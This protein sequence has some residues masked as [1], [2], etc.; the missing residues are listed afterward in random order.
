M[1]EIMTQTKVLLLAVGGLVVALL[2]CI[3]SASLLVNN[4]KEVPDGILAI[5]SAAVGALSTMLVTPR[6]ERRATDF[7]ERAPRD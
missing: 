3:V 4:N 1:K 5:G 7:V 6:T 2:V